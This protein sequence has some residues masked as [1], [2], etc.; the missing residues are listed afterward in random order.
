MLLLKEIQLLSKLVCPA[1]IWDSEKVS[2]VLTQDSY[3]GRHIH[4]IAPV[5][6]IGQPL[7]ELGKSGAKENTGGIIFVYANL[8]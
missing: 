1:G 3:H 5:P 4:Q 6:S 7:M 2:W 8:N